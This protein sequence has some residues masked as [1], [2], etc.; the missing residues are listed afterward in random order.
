MIL[1]ALT[2][3]HTPSVTSNNCILYNNVAF[4][5]KQ[6]PVPVIMRVQVPTEGKPSFIVKQN[7]CMAPAP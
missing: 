7:E 6:K 1:A 4:F 3:H 2:A 5:L